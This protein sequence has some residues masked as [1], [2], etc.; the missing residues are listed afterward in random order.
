MNIKNR[1]KW[2]IKR[3]DDI[4]KINKA[5]IKSKTY[6]IY[7]KTQNKKNKQNE[8]KMLTKRTKYVIIL[9]SQDEKTKI[10]IKI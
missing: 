5:N 2:Q 1:L 9:L 3:C 6:I 7:I 4:L 8:K 10:E